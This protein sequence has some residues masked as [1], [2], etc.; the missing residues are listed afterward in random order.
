MLG[1]RLSLAR[2]DE[3]TQKTSTLSGE[4]ELGL[5]LTAPQ[6]DD[7]VVLK[8]RGV[9]SNLNTD[10]IRSQRRSKNSA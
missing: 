2:S 10:E 6:T 8:G 1:P 7:Y 4:N 3:M 9:I 5:V